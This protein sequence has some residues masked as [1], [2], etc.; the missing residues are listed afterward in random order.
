MQKHYVF[1]IINLV[2]INGINNLGGAYIW[3]SVISAEKALLSE[4][5]SATHTEDPTELGNPT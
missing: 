4:L 1:G 2:F 3:Q 5:K